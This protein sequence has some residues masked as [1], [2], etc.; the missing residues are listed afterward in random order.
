MEVRLDPEVY[1]DLK[2]QLELNLEKIMY[3]YGS[4]VHCVRTSIIRKGVSAGELCAYLLALPAFDS[5]KLKLSLLSDI[6]AELEKATTI[7]G[8][9]NVLNSNYATFI[10]YEIFQRIA[11]DF[12]IDQ[13]R[14]K[15]K[16]PEH[17][18]AYIKMHKLS[19]FEDIN[20]MLKNIESGSKKMVLKFDIELTR[21][22][23]KLQDLTRAVAKLLGLR[24]SALRLLHI[25]EGCVIVTLLIP[26]LVADFIFSRVDAF[27][28]EEVKEFQAL[29]ILWL[30]CNGHKYEF[31]NVHVRGGDQK[32]HDVIVKTSG[33]NFLCQYYDYRIRASYYFMSHGIS[34]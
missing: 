19:E 23:A 17:L 20:P 12:D 7:N 32:L 21:A 3:Q 14:D 26:A 24:P 25:E 33:N 29:S 6:R 1:A 2:L 27:A 28:S 34:E 10:N 8:I 13:D 30:E 22:L 15:M 9:F 11:D 31:T 5:I 4:Y 16:Y 18:D